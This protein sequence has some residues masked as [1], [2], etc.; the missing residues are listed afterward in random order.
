MTTG[1]AV[2]RDAV[3]AD[4]VVVGSGIV[5]LCTAAAVV[6]RGG[7]VVVVAPGDAPVSEASGGLIRRFDLDAGPLAELAS[8]SF[9]HLR[10]I[11]SAY[12]AFQPSGALTLQY[13]HDP[14][15]T[16]VR[17][18]TVPYA[19]QSLNQRWP[20]ITVAPNVI[21]VFESGA[22]WIDAPRMLVAGRG[23]LRARGACFVRDRAVRVIT[24]RGRVR[25]VVTAAGDRIMARRVVLA[26]GAG[27]MALAR[28]AE[29]SYPLRTRKIG[30]CYFRVGRDRI[31]NLPSVVDRVGA[32]WVRPCTNPD[33]VLAG[34]KVQVFGVPAEVR[35]EI[36]ES[37][38]R[39]I[40]AAV[41]PI[42][43]L[44]ADAPVV[45]GV[46]AYDAAPDFAT[47][48]PVHHCA[49]PHG[50]TIAAGWNGG[51]FKAAPAIAELALEDRP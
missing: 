38:V 1:A 32:A 43:P 18:R 41:A 13:G 42:F 19:S 7:R 36:S 23:D 4:I 25:G 29:V 17:T 9:D 8:A 2:N 28:T 48:G 33:F 49:D 26:A 22:G 21:G 35:H 16:H 31:R 39:Q 3:D 50:L 46:T 5:G 44:V 10:A 30:Y 15:P 6:H 34:H 51:G 20:Q 45:G 27:S 14:L 47:P 24:T 12:C 37:D 40:R 11:A